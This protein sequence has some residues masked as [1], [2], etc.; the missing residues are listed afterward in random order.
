MAYEHV[1]VEGGLG[2]P[3]DQEVTDA[4]KALR[5]CKTVDEGR[6]IWKNLLRAIRQLW[7]GKKTVSVKVT[8]D[9]RKIP[10]PPTYLFVDFLVQHPDLIPFVIDDYCLFSESIGSVSDMP[11]HAQSRSTD[12]CRKAGHMGNLLRDL[13]YDADLIP[14]TEKER[15]QALAYQFDTFKSVLLDEIFCSNRPDDREIV[16]RRKTRE[17]IGDLLGG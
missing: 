17:R 7:V 5:E 3:L 11:I 10:S 4:V 6:P 15:Q 16:F 8:E 14:F 12:E 13:G 1:H 9:G 2:S